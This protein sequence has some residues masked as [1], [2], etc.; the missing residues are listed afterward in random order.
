[1]HDNLRFQRHKVKIMENKVLSGL[2]FFNSRG[3]ARYYAEPENISELRDTL[4][5]SR[6]GGLTVTVIGS[7]TH[8]ILPDSG[9]SGILIS[10]KKLKGITVKGS[11]ITALAG[12]SLDEV[13]NT[14]IEHNLMGL[15]RLGGI[16]GTIAAAM[17]I[18]AKSQGISIGDFHFYTDTMTL[19]GKLHRKPDY[20]DFFTSD[21]RMLSDDEIILSTTLHLREG[22]RTAEARIEKERYIELMFIPPC[23]NFIGAVFKDTE[24]YKAAEL[25]KEAGMTGDKGLRCE[26]S[27]FQSNCLFSYPDCR[28]SDVRKLIDMA[29]E[30]V[31]RE[32]GILLELS[33]SF[34]QNEMLSSAPSFPES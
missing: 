28:E 29:R 33:V 2:T 30:K 26:F 3:T 1:M 17:R 5:F 13:I 15:E 18:N 4:A 11:L 8:I 25:I 21:G 22:K 6:K 12:E 19:D 23:K 10:T 14:A 31:F 27:S 34:A 9:I 32:K 16:P 7:G 20:S 24:S